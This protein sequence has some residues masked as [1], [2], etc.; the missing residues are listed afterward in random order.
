MKTELGRL[1]K[2]GLEDQFLNLNFELLA[3][4]QVFV[5]IINGH[6]IRELWGSSFNTRIAIMFMK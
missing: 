4:R 2:H 5:K 3:A 1:S 6:F